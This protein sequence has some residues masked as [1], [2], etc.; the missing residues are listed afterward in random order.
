MN[1]PPICSD[2]GQEMQWQ[3]CGCEDGLR[4]GYDDDP[5]NCDPGD[6][7]T[8]PDCMG[9][10]GYWACFCEVHESAAEGHEQTAL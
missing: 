5:L 3:E 9:K 10:G 4:D 1:N 6:Y 8:C 2:C 7:Y